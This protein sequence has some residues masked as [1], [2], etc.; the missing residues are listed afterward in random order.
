MKIS[1]SPLAGAWLIDIE[2]KYDA[3]GFFARTV[4]ATT[5][6]SHGL[7]GVFVQQSVSWNRFRGTLRGLHFQIAPHAED[8]LIR[9]TRGRVFDVI[10]DLRPD[11]STQNRWYATELAAEQHRALYVPKG[12]AHGFQTLQDDTELLYEMSASFQPEYARGIRW[13]DPSLGITW[14]DSAGAIVSERDALLPYLLNVR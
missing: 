2:P 4:C 3:R 5:F 14:P 12:F 11:S 13:D 6:E 8:K 7:C 1:P 10:V 9:V